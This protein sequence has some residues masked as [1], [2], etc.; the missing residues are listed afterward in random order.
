MTERKEQSIA[1]VEHDGI[2][3]V[4]KVSQFEDYG[5]STGK[6]TRRF[7]LDSYGLCNVDTST[8]SYYGF[9]S[10]DGHW[11]IMKINSGAYTYAKGDS[12]YSAAWTARASQ[13]YDTFGTI[14]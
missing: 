8:P 4:K 1:Q 14:F 5:D 12:G 3:H 7:S 2:Y 10:A 11:Y 9:E 6:L 13:S